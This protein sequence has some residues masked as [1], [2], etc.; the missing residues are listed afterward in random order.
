M[1]TFGRIS[2]LP[3]SPVRAL[4]QRPRSGSAARC[5][6]PR[7]R[8]VGAGR[9]LSLRVSLCRLRV[10]G[11]ARPWPRFRPLSLPLDQT[12][13]GRAA[14]AGPVRSSARCGWPG[15]APAPRRACPGYKRSPPS[16]DNASLWQ[17][18]PGS[19]PCH[20]SHGQ[21]GSQHREALRAALAVFS[22]SQRWV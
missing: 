22:R 2:G 3:F 1:L 18:A 8:S 19:G 5:A 6:D 9:A 7:P 12:S 14:Q 10:S 13:S 15:R 16:Q 17:P 20:G 4:A 11:E 21:S